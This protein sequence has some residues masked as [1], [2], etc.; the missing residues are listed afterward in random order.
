MTKNVNSAHRFFMPMMKNAEETFNCFLQPDFILELNHLLEYRDENLL[1]E[2]VLAQKFPLVNKLEVEFFH[3]VLNTYHEIEQ[4]LFL[5]SPLIH[6]QIRNQVKRDFNALKKQVKGS[7]LKAI[8]KKN[9]ETEVHFTK[10]WDGENRPSEFESPPDQLVERFVENRRWYSEYGKFLNKMLERYEFELRF[11]IEDGFRT[12]ITSE[13]H[14]ESQKEHKSKSESTLA[15]VS[16]E[17]YLLKKE[18]F[19][20]LC[21][22]LSVPL[23]YGK[24]DETKFIRKT[25]NEYKWTGGAGRGKGIYPLGAFIRCLYLNDILSL[26]NNE[27]EKVAR[28]FLVFFHVQLTKSTAN[29]LARQISDNGN[30]HISFFKELISE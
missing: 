2:Q 28:S 4:L 24:F 15:D 14:L 26:P 17:N 27:M 6:P 10:G 23:A 22:K 1:D 20:E 11:F 16:F 18:R 13:K 3:C 8:V 9:N 7:N 30:P 21:D 5:S 19:Y 29:T 25:G 12:A